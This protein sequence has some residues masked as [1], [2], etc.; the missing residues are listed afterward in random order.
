M[1]YLLTG[2]AGQNRFVH[3]DA[4]DVAKERK[5]RAMK[6]KLMIRKADVNQKWLS[7]KPI[8]ITE[9]KRLGKDEYW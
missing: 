6:L 8:Y 3:P 9:K 1:A 7:F 5:P 4:F 2:S